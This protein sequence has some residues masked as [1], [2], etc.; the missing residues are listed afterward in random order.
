MTVHRSSRTHGP[1]IARY[2]IATAPMVIHQ[3]IDHVH[4]FT[5]GLSA[6]EID[7]TSKAA[8]EIAALYEWLTTTAQP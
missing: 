3:R 6:E 4:G 7:R 8:A 2:G 5:S 1:A